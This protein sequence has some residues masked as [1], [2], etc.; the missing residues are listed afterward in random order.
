MP[1]GICA[2]LAGCMPQADYDQLKARYD[3][4]QAAN[5]KLETENQAL[6]AQL[7]QQVQQSTYAIAADMLF[8]P[9]DFDVTP[10]GQAALT[11]IAGR[12]RG[13]KRGKIAVYGYTDDQKPGA[14]LKKLGIN[15]NADLSTKRADVV[16]NYLRTH[17]IS[18][19][20]L[21]A[22]GRG[23]THPIAPNNTPAG[24]AQNRRIEIVVEGSGS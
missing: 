6:Q 7:S 1:I 24:R 3:Q 15:N 10:T 23:E 5:Q 21:S 19:N 17:G 13:L 18:A 11:D 20:M 9:D 4:T 16:A 14:A 22:K 2:L 8:A 12:L